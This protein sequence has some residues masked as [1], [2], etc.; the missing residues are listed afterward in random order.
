VSEHEKESRQVDFLPTA[1]PLLRNPR[2]AYSVELSVLG[3]STRFESN[4][5]HVIG[6][7]EETFGGW[8]TVDA[9][10]PDRAK[11]VHVRITVLE[12]TEPAPH[13]ARHIAV[14]PARL[15]I[16][17]SG[18]VA[19]VDPRDEASVAYVT[20][21]LVAD[22]G[23]FRRAMVEPMTLALLSH[24]DRHPLHAAAVARDG[25]AVLLAG[26]SG[27]GKSTL[28]H[29]AHAAGFDVL[30][31][32]HVW[33]QLEPTVRIWGWPRDAR[34]LQP[35][36]SEKVHVPLARSDAPS[37]YFADSAVVAVLGRSPTAKLEP[38]NAPTLINELER[39]VA[40]GFDRFPERHTS[41]VR[42]LA[43]RGGWRLTLSRDP[44]DALP[45]LERMVSER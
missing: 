36:S 1:D 22:H 15:I 35:G 2:L 23:H 44:A 38:L 12:G 30:G 41:V 37:S 33:V 3:I 32:D 6:V 31:E 10:L 26:P 9:H 8:R 21:A 42:A 25:R 39:D 24:F 16:H 43:S 7:V 29:S 11:R 27:A 20:A 19:I 17:T 5:R 14:D 13:V 4:S 18:S 45:L 28:A 34:L 40:P